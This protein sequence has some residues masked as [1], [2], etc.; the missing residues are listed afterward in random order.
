MPEQ[1]K[2]TF[3]DELMAAVQVTEP[4]IC[5]ATL[6]E[7]WMQGRAAFGGL[8]SALGATALRK[9]LP[10]EVADRPL[11]GLMTAFI[12]P[13]G[14][15]KLQVRC[16]ELRSGRTATWAEARIYSDDNLCTTLTACLGDARESTIAVSPSVRPDVKPVE[17]SM[18][19]PFMPG[20]TPNFTQHYDMHWA[21]GQM[22]MSGSALSE[23]GVWVRYKNAV[24][25]T[26]AHIVALMDVLPPAVLQMYKEM[27]PISS[28]TWHLEMLDDLKASDT[29]DA[30]G[31]W[32]FHVKADHAAEGYSTQNATLYTPT[33]RAVA[34]SQQTIA[35]FG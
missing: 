29:Q 27:K 22:P 33:G 34:M 9:C 19:F 18:K 21:I 24:T 2:L 12:G 8:M 31:W 28:L 13:P 15:G 23:M 5:T 20:L 25:I 35:I 7:D 3:F 16:Q 6:T 32:F 14:E 4:S 11:R 30:E 10:T 26:E 1:S 17:E